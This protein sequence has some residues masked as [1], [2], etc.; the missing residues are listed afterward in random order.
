MVAWLIGVSPHCFSFTLEEVGVK[1]R[2]PGDLL[3]FYFFFLSLYFYPLACFRVLA[4]RD[5]CGHVFLV[6]CKGIVSR[7]Y[8]ELWFSKNFDGCPGSKRCL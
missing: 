5:F 1:F 8:E 7:R 4:S 2:N 3:F 6:I